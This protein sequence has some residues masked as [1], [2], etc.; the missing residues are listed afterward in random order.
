MN[1]WLNA[2]EYENEVKE[3]ERLRLLY[4]GELSEL[5]DKRERLIKE[6]QLLDYKISKLDE[7]IVNLNLNGD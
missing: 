4:I 6:L 7:L 3:C 5:L 1:D 2:W